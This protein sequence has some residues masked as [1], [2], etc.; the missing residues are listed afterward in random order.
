MKLPI[1]GILFITIGISKVFSQT[2]L[3]TTALHRNSI[4]QNDTLYV[5]YTAEQLVS[6]KYRTNK[7]YYWYKNDSIYITEYG[8]DGRLLNGKFTSYFPNKSLYEKGE[9]KFGTKD[10]VWKTWYPNGKL[11]FIMT[12]NMGR[13]KKNMKEFD[14]N[15][16][17]V[18]DKQNVNGKENENSE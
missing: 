12:W 18:G 17:P 16:I 11:H 13:L 4:V 10:G 14:M 3:S 2:D 15:G 1:L 9:F 6:I 8:S 5:F 7:K